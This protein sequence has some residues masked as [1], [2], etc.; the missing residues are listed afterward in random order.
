MEQIVVTLKHLH[1]NEEK[2]IGLKFYPKKIVQTI[3]KGLPK[4]KW[5][6]EFNMAYITNNKCNLDLI[7]NDFRGIAWINSGRSNNGW[8]GN[9]T[10]GY[11]AGNAITSGDYNLVLVC[12]TDVSSGT[13]INAT[14]IGNGA[15]VNVSNKMQLGNTSVT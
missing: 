5:S 7:F 6:K 9:V 4:V 3:V 1:I 13:L 15:T 2:Q 14:A 10:L 8:E 12:D 11:Q